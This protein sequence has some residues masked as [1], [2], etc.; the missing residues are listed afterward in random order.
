MSGRE[1]YRD[2]PVQEQLTVLRRGVVDI[3][4]EEDLLARL[5]GAQQTGRPLRVKLG[6]DPTSPDIHLGHT[7]VLR[8][9]RQFQDLGHTAV[10]IIGD[11]TALVGDP[12]GQN[13]TRPAVSRREIEDN[14]RTYFEQVSGILDMER[15]E[16]VRNSEWFRELSFARLL[17]LASKVTVAR[18]MERDDFQ[19]RWS[20][21]QPIGMHELLYPVMQ[22]YD[23]IMISSDVELGGTDQTFNLLMGRQMQ[24]DEGQQP[25][26]ALTMPILVGL[27]GVE[28]M[29]KSK[30]NYIG[31]TDSPD[32]M[33]GKIMSIGDDLMENYFE[34][35][36]SVEQT[37]YRGKLDFDHPRN[38]KAELA[39]LIVAQFHGQEAAARAAERFDR[40]FREREQ[41]L[42]MPEITICPGMLEDGMIWLVRLV[43]EAGFAASSSQARRLIREG[44]VSLD[45]QRMLD[46]D[47]HVA[48][49]DGQVLK[50]GKRRFAR[51]TIGK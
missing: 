36:T 4:T 7:V 3:T 22:G 32:E 50:V 9:L 28:K 2:L 49:S 14:A 35:L 13:K 17:E 44:A 29:S 16:I 12:S 48:V 39:S 5:S 25:Q 45:D 15:A 41:P 26:V 1:S 46:A 43:T 21:H 19:Q 30:G 6:V 23:S 51:I 11:Y 8:K 37:R 10:L 31:V 40:V 33:Y 18:I 42:D 34:L 47:A 38:V 20:R 27:D 24:R